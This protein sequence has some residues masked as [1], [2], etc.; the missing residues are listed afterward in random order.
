MFDILKTA[1]NLNYI[2]KFSSYFVSIIKTNRLM[3]YREIT[4]AYYEYN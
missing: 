4:G 2:K 1:T 3:V